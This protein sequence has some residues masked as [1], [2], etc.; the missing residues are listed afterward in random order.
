MSRGE[1]LAVAHWPPPSS[2]P[3]SPSWTSRVASCRW[4]DFVGSAS[5]RLKCARAVGARA[6]RTSGQ[7]RRRQPVTRRPR[8][9]CRVRACATLICA[10]LSRPLA[11]PRATSARRESDC[12]TRPRLQTRIAVNS[13]LAS[14]SITAKSPNVLSCRLPNENKLQAIENK[15]KAI[16]FTKRHDQHFFLYGGSTRLPRDCTL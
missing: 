8:A 16:F 7:S 5:A 4:R 15:Q 14:V 10:Q 9:A 6:S 11:R 13:K 12:H 2:P 1:E 3:S